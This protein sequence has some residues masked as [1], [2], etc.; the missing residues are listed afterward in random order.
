MSQL[1]PQHALSSSPNSHPTT[2]I[3]AYLCAL[4]AFGTSRTKTKS[5]KISTNM[6]IFHRAR[7][8][9]LLA[10]ISSFL[11]AV[12]TSS[13]PVCSYNPVGPLALEASMTVCPHAVDNETAAATGSWEPWSFFLVCVQ[14]I[15]PQDGKLCAYTLASFRGG[16][17]ISF[18]TTPELAADSVHLLRDRDDRW[19]PNAGGRP[20]VPQRSP[21]YIIKSVSGKGLGAEANRTILEG[22]VILTEKPRIMRISKFQRWNERDIFTILA[23]AVNRLPLDDGRTIMGMARSSCGF[24]LDDVLNTNA[25]SVSLGD[26]EH[27]GLFPAVAVCVVFTAWGQRLRNDAAD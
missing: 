7:R 25:F 5:R 23:Q 10:L 24:G 11:E 12:Y 4:I 1:Q 26:E 18:V 9:C 16:P 14:A 17:G 8:I 15:R 27:S 3:H 13:L 20:A 19:I 6:T 21:P 2:C 22:E